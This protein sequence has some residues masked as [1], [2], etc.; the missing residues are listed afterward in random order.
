MLLG[1]IS[2]EGVTFSHCVPAIL[3]MLL[4]APEAAGTDL[5]RWKVVIGGS[6]LPIG[7]ARRAAAHG[8]E[9]WAGYGMS[10]TCPVLTLSQIK[11]GARFDAEANLERR[12]K[13]G[14]PIP[15]VQLRVVDRELKERPRDGASVGEV[16]VRA[17]WLTAG[18]VGDEAASEALWQGGWLHT[19]D[20][21]HIDAE[22]YLQ[23]TDRLKDVIKTGGE[24]ISSLE[25]ESH[26]SLHPAVAEVAVVGVPDEHWGERPLALVV[27]KPEH[28]LDPAA[29]LD[30]LKAIVARGMLPRY[31]LPGRVLVI[32]AIPKTSV[33]KIDKK[34]LRQM[35]ASA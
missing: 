26:I 11:P 31:A 16:T 10:E 17:P 18:Y 30:H 2:R 1:L 27:A 28:G 20:V 12:C 34:Q 25:L 35:F 22:G 15:L 8:I 23:I 24:W 19:Q 6:A 5:S 21:G 7:L 33:G 13:T 9:V 4:A 3:Q 32:D 14:L 29:I